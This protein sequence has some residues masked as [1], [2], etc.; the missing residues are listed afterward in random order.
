MNNKTCFLTQVSLLSVF[1][2]VTGT[3]KIPSIFP[4]AEFQL[5][6]PI[7]VAICAVFGF[8]KYIIAGLIASF[9]GLALGTQNLLAVIIAMTFRLTVGLI[10]T[11]CGRSPLVISIAGPIGSVIGRLVLGSIVGKAVIPLIIAALPGMIFTAITSYPM[12]KLF[13][14]VQESFR[15]SQKIG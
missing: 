11:V 7:A 9:I 1:I 3:F 10:L 14:K 6:A 2:F 4:G 13:K 8:K 12:V 15:Y 5:S